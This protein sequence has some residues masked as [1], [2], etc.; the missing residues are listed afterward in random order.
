V[1]LVVLQ[2]M[3]VHALA[4]R[5]LPPL[6][7]TNSSSSSSNPG[8]AAA[9]QQ[10]PAALPKSLPGHLAAH[11]PLLRQRALSLLAAPL[12]GDMLAAE[13]LL[14][15]ALGS[16]SQQQQFLPSNLQQSADVLR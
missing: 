13:Y 6:T 12:A 15:S 7:T 10:Q 4:I 2:V 3:R 8:A 9:P 1:L 5:K 11:L 16:V 14:L